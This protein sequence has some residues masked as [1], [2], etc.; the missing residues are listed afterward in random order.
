MLKVVNLKKSYSKFEVLK[1]ISFEI[2]KGTVYGFLGQNGAGKSTTMNILT[3]L[4]DY[5][6]G[7]IYI[8]GKDFKANRFELIKK[9][10]YLTENPVFYNYMNAYEYLSFLGEI[11][12][13]KHDKIKYR[14]DEL[15]ELV[16][17][18]D[19][20]KRRVGGYSRG[21][22]QR[23]GVAIAMFN[24][25]EILFLDEPTSALD[26]GGRME[27]MDLIEGLKEQNI[28]VF[29]SSHIL[30]DVERVCD[31][32]SILHQGK[33]ILS[34]KLEELKN[35]YIQPIYDMEFEKKCSSIS[36]ALTRL[37]WVQ[38]VQMEGSKKLSVY[39]KDINTA[40]SRLLKELPIEDNH[41]L[42]FQLRKNNLEDIFMRMVKNDGDI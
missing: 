10:G 19:A 30:S 14:I 37:D 7:E 5:N 20:A 25:P 1:E 32:V 2:K 41:I 16:K 3:G 27:M 18:K 12:G 33:I 34:D 8:N 38:N 21:M 28:T 39:V 23:L 31:E 24:R 22:K 6:G 42:S 36:D 29:L 26:P 4:I 35:K 9:I 17:L 13:Y 11:S 40:N 15:L